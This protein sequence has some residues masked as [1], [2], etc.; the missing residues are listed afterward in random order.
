[1]TLLVVPDKGWNEHNCTRIRS[2]L[3][4]LVDGEMEITV[5]TVSEIPKEKSGKRPII[6]LTHV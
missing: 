3:S 4:R 6:K 5:E 2:D 1:M